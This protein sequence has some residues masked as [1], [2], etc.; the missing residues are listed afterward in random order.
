MQ[1]DGVDGKRMKG[2]GNRNESGKGEVEA[3]S[4]KPAEQQTTRPPPEPAMQ[5]YIHVRA[6]RGQATDSHSLAE[7]VIEL[8]DSFLFVKITHF[9]YICRI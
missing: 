2:S 7:R 8:F 3:S 6:R 1:S 5:D 9:S 4:G